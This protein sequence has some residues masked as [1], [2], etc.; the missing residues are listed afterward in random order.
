M[1]KSNNLEFNEK[2]CVQNLRTAIG[3]RITPSHAN[4]FM[5][6]MEGRLLEEAEF[7]PHTCWRYVDDIFIVWTE[8][9]EKLREFIDYLNNA[10]DTINFTS[11]WSRSEIEFLDVRV[12]NGC[13]RLETDLFMV[14]PIIP[15]S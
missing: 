6:K 11:K 12:I 7:K 13:G 2:H 5:D 10:L 15:I 8:G 9:E 4:I 3:T 1:L 14:R